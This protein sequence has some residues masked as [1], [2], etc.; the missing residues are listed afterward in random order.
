MEL[1]TFFSF[2]NH[3]WLKTKQM[4]GVVDILHIFGSSKYWIKE[5]NSG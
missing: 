2:K 1:M 5:F 4:I 3:H